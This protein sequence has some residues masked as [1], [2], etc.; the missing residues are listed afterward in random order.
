MREKFQ[1]IGCTHCL[2][3]S[4]FKDKNSSST[5]KAAVSVVQCTIVVWGKE[6]GQDA[7]QQLIYL[8]QVVV[9]GHRTLTVFLLVGKPTGSLRK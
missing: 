5:F 6:G 4:G 9:H 8:D 7:T 3:V 1:T 2:V